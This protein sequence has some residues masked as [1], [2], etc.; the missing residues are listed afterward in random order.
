[1][2]EKKRTRITEVAPIGVLPVEVSADAK[3]NAYIHWCDEVNA[4]VLYAM[5]RNHMK[6][7]KEGALDSIYAVCSA[8]I[9][10]RRCPARHLLEEEKT[11]GQAIYFIERVQN[12]TPGETQ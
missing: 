2:I 12:V 7:R 10:A 8:A 3:R 11:K 9:G 1:M 6:N 4:R 5:C